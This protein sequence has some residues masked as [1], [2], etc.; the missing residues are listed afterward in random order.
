MTK[1]LL[2]TL[3]F[4]LIPV[5]AS[6]VDGVVLI[7]HSTV[8]TSGGFPYVISQPG[9]SKLSGNLVVDGGKD[10]IEISTSN[11]FLDLNGFDISCGGATD[12]HRVA[13]ISGIAAVHDI[14]IRN[15][16]ISETLLLQSRSRSM[17]SS[18]LIRQLA[19]PS[20]SE[21]RYRTS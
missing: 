10:G 16:T 7:N 12:S 20:A 15:G 6:G 17:A 5:C 21:S 19:I 18:S 1:H 11:V 9:S 8:T 4:T 2:S 14:S 3:A 13:S